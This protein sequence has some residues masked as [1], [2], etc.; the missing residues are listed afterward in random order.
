MCEPVAD[1]AMV[2]VRVPSS[3]SSDCKS[4]LE[5]HGDGSQSLAEV[6]WRAEG[7]QEASWRHKAAAV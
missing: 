7:G 6:V 3:A 1:G 5:M 2:E 4:S